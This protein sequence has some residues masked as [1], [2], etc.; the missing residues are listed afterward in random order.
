MVETKGPMRAR[1]PRFYEIL[2][3]TTRTGASESWPSQFAQFVQILYNPLEVILEPFGTSGGTGD[4]V[5]VVLVSGLAIL[6][7]VI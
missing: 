6:V 4:N 7:G 3:R 5:R 1:A 2:T